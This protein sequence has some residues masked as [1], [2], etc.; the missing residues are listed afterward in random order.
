MLPRHLTL[1]VQLN[2]GCFSP[3]SRQYAQSFAV[4]TRYEMVCMHEALHDAYTFCFLDD[5]S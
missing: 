2:L 4:L 5:C 3:R 1:G